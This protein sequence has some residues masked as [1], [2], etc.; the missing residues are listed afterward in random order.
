MDR[1]EAIRRFGLA[2]LGGGMLAER[3]STRRDAR[4][5]ETRS[6]DR[7]IDVVL[8][9]ASVLRT[10]AGGVQVEHG[11][12]VRLEGDRIVEVAPGTLVGGDRLDLSGHLLLPG[13]ISGHTHVAAGSSTRGIIESGRSYARPLTLVDEAFSD[14]ELDAL[15]AYNLAELLVSGCTGQVEMS[16]SLRQARSYARVARRLGA[17]GWVGGMV[18]GIGRLFPIWFGSD[19]DLQASEATT[20]IEIEANRSFAESLP[21]Q[22]DGLILG[23]MTP[24]AADTQTPATLEAFGRAAARLGTGIHT[25]LSQ[26]RR[27]TDAVLRRHGVTP[28]RW[29]ADAGLMDG[30]FFGAHFTGPDWGSDPAILIERGAVYATCPSA[31]G[32]GGGTQPY[33]E[34]LAAGLSVNVGID[35]HSNDMLENVK[36]AVL[37]GQARAALL[38]EV[39]A[40]RPVRA[41]TVEDA[42]LGCTVVPARAL[43]R[44]DLGVIEPGARADLVAVDVRGFLVGSGATPPEPLNNL[45][46]AGGHSVSWVFVDGRPI[47]SDGV[48]ADADSI[49]AEGGRVARRLWE[50]LAAEGWFD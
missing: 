3:A 38:R 40:G 28:T 1:R 13:L 15:T 16:M 20:L 7:V 44:P 17:R 31:G 41:P 12:S 23:M 9:H 47:V 34:A 8:E 36:L 26:G 33:P 14:E 32:A 35:T 6:D 19:D 37:Q 24:H 5:V 10:R 30:P 48:L 22:G 27:E 42:I 46:Y 25:H 49:V 45:L 4:S 29:L 50:G 43:Q 21:G 11:V 2:G 18:P 39:S